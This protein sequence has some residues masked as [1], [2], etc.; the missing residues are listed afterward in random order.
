MLNIKIHNII[1]NAYIGENMTDIKDLVNTRPLR[2]EVGNKIAIRSYDVVPNESYGQV[3]FLHCEDGH[4]Y[5][6]TSEKILE[7]LQL[8]FEDAKKNDGKLEGT[9]VEKK[10][11]T[12]GR[13][14][15]LL[16]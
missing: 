15:L 5:Y 6:T 1:N 10:T 4:A 14:V 3:V 8:Y 7:Q 12:T 16:E 13:K 2:E 11:K 9:V